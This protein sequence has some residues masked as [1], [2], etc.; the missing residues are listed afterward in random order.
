MRK[1]FAIGI[2]IAR[3]IGQELRQMNQLRKDTIATAETGTAKKELAKRFWTKLTGKQKAI[4][5]LALGLV[6]YSGYSVLFG[7][8]RQNNMSESYSVRCVMNKLVNNGTGNFME[9]QQ[10]IYLKV[11]TA[12]N[13]AQVDWP[14]NNGQIDHF[15]YQLKNVEKHGKGNVFSFEPTTV[16]DAAEGIKLFA[17]S[18]TNRLTLLYLLP[19]NLLMQGQCQAYP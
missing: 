8:S 3:S 10:A 2:S 15:A 11:R 12:R 4:L 16:G 5:T 1:A 6:A 13:T 7:S 19:G 17:D 14:N 9:M 18:Q